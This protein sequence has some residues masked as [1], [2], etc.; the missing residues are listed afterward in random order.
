[1]VGRMLRAMQRRL[2]GGDLESL[3]AF[4]ALHEETGRLIEDAVHDLR[5]EPHCHSWADIGRV[6]GTSR[7]AAQQRFGGDG[8]RRPGGQPGDLR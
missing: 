7:Q 4:V 6:L 2:A 5:A 3:A 1:M 8:A